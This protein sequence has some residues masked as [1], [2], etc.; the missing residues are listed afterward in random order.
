MTQTKPSSYQ[1]PLPITTNSPPLTTQ[2]ALNVCGALRCVCPCDD[3]RD[4]K[5]DDFDSDVST[6]DQFFSWKQLRNVT[7]LVLRRQKPS[8]NALDGL[9]LPCVD[10]MLEARWAEGCAGSLPRRTCVW[11]KSCQ[12]LPFTHDGVGV[13]PM[14]RWHY[15]GRL[16]QGGAILNPLP[17]PSALRITLQWDSLHVYLNMVRV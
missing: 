17:L 9:Y 16:Y 12:G 7:I 10:R 4:A 2:H 1:L 13:H 6:S 5:E 14:G 3:D 8:T 11:W 15:I